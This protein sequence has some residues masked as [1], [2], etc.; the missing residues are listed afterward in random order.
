M[1]ITK[2]ANQLL[3]RA[4]S[5]AESG[6]SWAQYS[7]E[8]FD[9]RAGLVAQSFPESVERQAFYDMPEYTEVY[10]ILV[11]L[12]KKQGVV[13]GSVPE[14]SGRFLVRVP[15]TV[16]EVLAV[17]ARREG[18]SLNQ[19]AA[20]KLALP[21]REHVNLDSSIIIQ[22][23]T[24]VHD[25]YASDRVV[26]DPVLNPKFI[27]AC[28][29]LGLKDEPYRLNH[30]LFDIR[31]SPK[32]ALPATTK[33]TEFRDFD[34]YQFGSEIAVRT[35]QRTEGVTLD[36]ILCDPTLAARFDGISGRLVN[37]KSALK[38]RWAALNLRKTR[39]M[40]P[41]DLSGPTYQL[42]SAGPLRSIPLQ[43]LEDMPAVYAI[44]DRSQALFAGETESLRRRVELHLSPG[45]LPEWIDPADDSVVL[46][47]FVAPKLLSAERQRWLRQFLNDR[48]TVLNYQRSA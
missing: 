46:K 35:L 30:A 25:G 28:H 4:K 43:Q 44:Y 21:L 14:K 42:I 2:K 3:E 29:A 36:R 10:T 26:V 1:S 8:L 40:T 19:L 38:R 37:E 48:P 20:S 18:V 45:R 33:K 31:K 11:R 24:D 27:A 32:G 13:G 17:E 34:E 5:I 7:N 23:F 39:R 15:R 9:Q 12:M 41:Q 16:H 6:V 47:K 22:A